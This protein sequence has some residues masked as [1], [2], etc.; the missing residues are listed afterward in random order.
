MTEQPPTPQPPHDPRQT[1][2]D[3]RARLAALPHGEEVTGTV[4]GFDGDEVVVRLDGDASGAPSGRIPR[5]LLSWTTFERPDEV[6]TVGQRVRAEI[7]RVDD[8]RGRVVL[9]AQACEDPALRRHLLAVRPGDVVAGTVAAVHTFG[10]FVRLDGAPPHPVYPGT[11][12][13][14]VPDLTWSRIDHPGDVVQPGLRVTGEVIHADSRNGEVVLSL[15]ALQPD[16]W[17]ALD[18]A[19]G[20]TVSGPVTKVIPLGVF[21]RVA[22]AV[23]GLVHTAELAGRTPGEG[24][25][26]S[27]RVLEADRARRRLR[28]TPADRP[29]GAAPADTGPPPARSGCA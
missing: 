4:T 3:L 13:V 1:L 10:V 29:P 6:M 8:R 9:S 5:H 16:P 15:K 26:L 27:V 12:F 25:V 24:E 18:L 19:A 28:L 11:G 17:D 20:D 2:E 14:R 23:E 7:Q 21:V 22:E